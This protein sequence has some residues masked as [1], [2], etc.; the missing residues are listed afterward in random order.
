MLP[1]FAMD[2]KLDLATA[3][4]QS[5]RVRAIRFPQVQY[6]Q[7]SIQYR[8]QYKATDNGTFHIIPLGVAFPTAEFM[9]S[10]ANTAPSTTKP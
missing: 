7:P 8:S 6:L 9:R 1:M 5:P 4:G 3:P 10:T 2:G